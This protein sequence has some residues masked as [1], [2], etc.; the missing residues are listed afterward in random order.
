M[1]KAPLRLVLG[2]TTMII[3]LGYLV[4]A[5]WDGMLSGQT[6]TGTVQEDDKK[7]LLLLMSHVQSNSI[8][9]SLLCPWKSKPL[10]FL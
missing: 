10:H 6:D 7:N 1:Q 2:I 5:Y 8:T 9:D 3:I 4:A